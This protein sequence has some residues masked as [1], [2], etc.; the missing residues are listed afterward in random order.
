MSVWGSLGG[1]AISALG[2][3]LGGKAQNKA[4]RE[5]SRE[6]M[7]FQERMSSTAYQR[8][9]VDMRKAGL[10]PILAYKQGGASSPTG[11]SIAAQ[12]VLGPAVSSAV[13]TYTAMENVKNVRADTELKQQQSRKTSNEAMRMEKSG[14]SLIGRQVYSGE[15]YLNR[16][17]QAIKRYL[18]GS[19]AKSPTLRVDPIG[20]PTGKSP[21]R[22]SK[23]VWERLTTP[24]PWER[25]QSK[26]RRR[27]R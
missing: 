23:S 12:N 19:S 2:S 7:A 14:D 22:S 20:P 26:R 11:A 15:V 10:N 9:M 4:N 24:S 3:Y 18:G 25:E 5:I 6:Q 17:I 27:K 1:A 13:Q 21:F 16:A 8:G